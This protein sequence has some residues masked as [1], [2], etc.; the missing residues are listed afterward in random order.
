M[1]KSWKMLWDLRLQSGMV[2]VWPPSL[3]HVMHFKGLYE[4]TE[5]EENMETISCLGFILGAPTSIMRY[6]PYD[7]KGGIH[8]KSGGEFDE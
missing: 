3:I 4:V 6:S 7:V 5:M 8:C 1:G 2:P